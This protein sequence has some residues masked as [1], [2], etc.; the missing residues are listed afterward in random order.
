MKTGQ[1]YKQI[2]IESEADL[3][4]EYGIYNVSWDGIATEPL[5]YDPNSIEGADEYT[6]IKSIKWYLLPVASE[7]TMLSDEEVRTEAKKQSKGMPTEAKRD[8]Y[9]FGFINCAKWFK[10]QI[11]DQQRE[12][13][14]KF[15]KQ[16]YSDEETCIHNVDEYLKSNL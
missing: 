1:H 7:V 11:S 8:G 5:A 14:I 15:A 12:E 10:S 2:F 6:W 9:V 13:L 3:P 16:F 4:K